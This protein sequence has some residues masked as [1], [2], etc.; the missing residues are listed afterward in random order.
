MSLDEEH[1]ELELREDGQPP[2]RLPHRAQHYLLLT[3]ARARTEDL[4][5]DPDLPAAEQGWRYRDALCRGLRI[6][7]NQFN[8]ALFRARQHLGK[9]GLLGAE[10]IVE[11]RRGSGQ[12][13]LGT[14][15]FTIEGL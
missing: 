10:G 1:V 14:A 15:R 2:L 11:R 5:E 9:A 6:P 8:V 13:R 12:L 4:E 7:E 3:L